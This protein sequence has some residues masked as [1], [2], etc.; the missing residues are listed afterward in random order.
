MASPRWL[1]RRTPPKCRGLAGFA[2]ARS[3]ADQL[4]V[5]LREEGSMRETLH[6]RLS[7][8]CVSDPAAA[9]LETDGGR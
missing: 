8:E 3:N 1:L 5:P 7:R 2:S 6:G 9:T 4:V